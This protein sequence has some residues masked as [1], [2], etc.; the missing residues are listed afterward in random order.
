M[1]KTLLIAAAALAAGII[2]SQAQP[3][4]SQNI[5]GYVNVPTAGG[6][7]AMDNPLSNN[8]NNS[9]T[10]L[11][12]TTSGANDGSV[13]L[14]WAGTHYS[15]TMFDSSKTTG[16]TDAAT[17]GQTLPPPVLAPGNGFLF[18]NQNASNTITFT[19][20]VAVD[21]PGTATNV[22]GVTTNILSHSTLYVFP[23][24]K[25]AVGGGISS[26]LGI[27]NVLGALDGSVVVIPNIVGGAIHGYTQIMFDSSKATGFTDAASGTQTLAEPVI[28][29]GGSFLFSNQSGSDYKWIQS[30]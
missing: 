17:G 23:S 25:I 11:F 12:N 22:V 29:V 8:G 16:F 5:V 6:Y 24:S 30:L 20:S 21:G 7:T 10:N 28:P 26:V 3:V 27:K 2:T 4:Y 1:K 18:N 9:A 14:T 19:G 15:Q 13:I